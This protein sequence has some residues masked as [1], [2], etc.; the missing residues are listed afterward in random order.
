MSWVSGIFVYFITYWTILFA[1]LPWGNHA[2]PNP[3]IGH[4]PSAPANPRLKQKFIATAIVSAIIWLV[5]FA[6]VKVE[7]IS[8][9]DAARQMS[10]EMKQ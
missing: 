4:A 6:L 7:V 1:I 10:V 8:F 5:I 2:D 3:A 9:H